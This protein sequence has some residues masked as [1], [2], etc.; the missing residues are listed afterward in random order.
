MVR[1]SAF[2]FIVSLAFS[3][4]V[5]IGKQQKDAVIYIQDTEP[6]ADVGIGAQWIH[7]NGTLKIANS[8]NPTVWI[9]VTGGGGGG[10]APVDATYITQTGNVTLTSEQILSVLGTGL[11]KNTTGTG[12]LSIASAPTDYIIDS[13]TRLTNARAPTVHASTHITGGS[14]SI[15]LDDLVLPDDNTDLDASI[16][17]HGLLQ[18]LPGGTTTF[19][20]AD[21]TF[22]TPAGGGGGLGYSINVQALTSSP[23]DGAT[24]YFGMLPKVPVTAAATSKIHIRVAGTITAANIYCY[25]GTAGTGEA[26]PLYI[27]KNNTTDTLIQTLSV[28]T[29]ERVF[30]NSALSI[31]VV[32]GDYIEIKGIQPTWVTNPLTT[33]Y[34][35]YVYIQ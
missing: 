20:R 17:R 25:S 33:I 28:T 23:G 22:A 16:T 14:D 29:N 3:S 18:K 12:V 34:G 1:V 8:L 19:L 2:I 32:A 4:L 30:T 7:S 26:W 6:T 27:R 11:L 31:A 10:G 35:G 5:L 21:G 13:D 9:T 15:K 24:V